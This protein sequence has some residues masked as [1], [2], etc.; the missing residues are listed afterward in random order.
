MDSNNFKLKIQHYIVIFI[1]SF[2]LGVLLYNV[3][4]I[5]NKTKVTTSYDSNGKHSDTSE[6]SLV[7]ITR[8]ITDTNFKSEIKDYDIKLTMISKKESIDS[9]DRIINEITP[10]VLAA[11]SSILKKLKNIDKYRIT[12]ENNICETFVGSNKLAYIYVDGKDIS[13]SH[14][15]NLYDTISQYSKKNYAVIV[16]IDSEEEINKRYI[17]KLCASKASLIFTKGSGK[18]TFYMENKC[19]VVY[20]SSY[21][22]NSYTPL[23]D[24]VF[25]NNEPVSL[26]IKLYVND[27]IKKMSILNEINANAENITKKL[28]ESFTFFEIN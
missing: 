2:L 28:D 5:F 19:L 4:F 15:K 27:P 1:L 6:I 18:S 26:G 10:T 25:A 11:N 22:N 3:F 24:I 17:S 13:I 16:I 9:A 20:N 7:P 12:D 23:I 14:I 8:D 21:Y